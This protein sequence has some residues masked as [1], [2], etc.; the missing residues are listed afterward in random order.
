MWVRVRWLVWYKFR[1]ALLIVFENVTA[2]KQFIYCNSDLMPDHLKPLFYR[3]CKIRQCQNVRGG[4]CVHLPHQICLFKLIEWEQSLHRYVFK[5]IC[6]IP[7]ATSDAIKQND[8]ESHV[9]DC[10][11]FD[12][13]R[14]C[15]RDPLIEKDAYQCNLLFKLSKFESAHLVWLMNAHPHP[16]FD[17]VMF[18]N[19]FI[20]YDEILNFQHRHQITVK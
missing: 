20:T 14:I 10:I 4:V 6:V 12:Y 2:H 11:P 5:W 18:R 13:I 19:T 15:G 17:T 1:P 9:P 3:C 7:P 8:N 16:H